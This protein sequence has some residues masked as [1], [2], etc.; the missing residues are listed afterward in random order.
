MLIIQWKIARYTKKQENCLI[1]IDPKV[2][3]NEI[4][5]QGL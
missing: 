5:R 1:E 3:D 2:V 4:N